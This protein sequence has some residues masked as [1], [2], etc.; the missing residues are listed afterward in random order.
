VIRLITRLIFV[1]FV[2]EKGLAPDALF[3]DREIRKILNDT[4]PR[5]ST[6][7]KAI[8]QN[9]FFA[10][11]NTEM[12][13]PDKPDNRKFRG[14]AK[15]TGGRDQH[16]MVHSLYR[17][18]RYFT[19]PTEAL[20]LFA[21][22]PFLNGGLFECLDKDNP[23]KVIRVD[24]FSDRPDNPLHVPNFL[25]FSEERY[26]DLNTAYGTSGKRYKVRGLIDILSRYK[27]AIEEN[28]PI[29]EEVAL[30]PELLGKVFE[31]LLAA[32]N[33]E[34]GAT[35]RKQT[36][37]FYTPREIVNYM[38]DESLV[39]YLERGLQSTI[40]NPQSAIEP[41]LRHLIAYNDEPHQFSEAETEGLIK[42]IDSLKIL[43]PACGSGAFPMGVLHKLVFILGKLDPRNARWKQRQID[44]VLKTMEMAEQIDDSTIR[45][46]TL[47]DLEREIESINEAF[48]RNELDY[49]RK[50]YLIE[51][52]IYG[53][54]IQ[55]IAVQIA[56]L[57][58]FISLIVDQRID[59]SRENRGVRPLPNL[60]TKFV[61]ANT[62][63]GV[64]KPAQFTLRNPEI[65]RKEKELADI[66]RRHFTA[67]TPQTKAK[68]R[69][70]DARIRAEISELLKRD[71]FPSETTEKIAYW[72]PYDQNASA[73]FFDPEWI[74][75][76]T[77]G[78]DVVIGNPPYVLGRETFGDKMK[79][80]L[81]ENY[82]AYGGKYDLYI[83]F[84]ERGIL[85]LKTDG[86]LA[87]IL[88]NTL[89][90]N[91]NAQNMRR[92]V[93]E[94]T[95]I[96]I[97]RTFNSKV[98]TTQVESIVIIVK[99]GNDNESDQVLIKGEKDFR[100]PQSFFA[101]NADFRFNLNIDPPT[102]DLIK[103]INNLSVPLGSISDIC[104]GIQLGGSSGSDSKESFISSI[105]KDETYKKML[106]GKDINSYQKSWKG[107]YVRYGNW[108]HRKRNERYFLN[109]KIIIRQIGSMPI[110]TYDEEQFYTLNTIY[111]LIGLDDG[112]SLKYFLGIINSKLGKW[113]WIKNN[114]DFKTLFPKIKKSQIEAIPIY[115]LNLANSDDRAK[116]NQIVA[117]VDRILSIKQVNPNT[118]VT[119]LED[120]IDQQVY[121]LYGLT[122]EEIA[123][124]E[125]AARPKRD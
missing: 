107:L 17:Y 42:A 29:E 95:S 48:E 52:C 35:A 105:K 51:N 93:L 116:H 18:E 85:L 76:I 125:E 97:I 4:D 96:K 39:A 75:G 21:S 88:P 101:E 84:T 62:L 100:I 110:A 40:R 24:G 13:T 34:T 78:F 53:V 70:L 9:L 2:K 123:I 66:R 3:D 23:P 46:N 37:S 27:F 87:Y 69:E 1:W 6:Y 38:V 77:E 60:E 14:Q 122:P 86:L 79:K 81:S 64:D 92:I 22:I 83:Y 124:V 103:N 115:D 65:D 44:R 117:L 58:F 41:R 67:R 94:N 109:P 102:V 91:V 19:D 33:P 73:D 55:P 63:I 47:R 26:V 50:L 5:A 68:Y 111:N 90:V 106:D 30:D 15:G 82:E 28:T 114:S 10:T 71:G 121:E 20:R 89:L 32:Y 99:K 120:E 12:N 98:F 80:Y 31:N 25:F 118:E 112:Y 45:E 7:Y 49:G 57:R 74:F 59:E 72:N 56:K 113:F 104:I 43:D 16:Y 108:L 11:L 36:G 8:L 54:D 119:D 61:A